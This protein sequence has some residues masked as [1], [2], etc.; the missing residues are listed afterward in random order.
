MAVAS[1][2]EGGGLS[3]VSLLIIR[4]EFNPR[5][6]N[7]FSTFGR[8]E[9]RRLRPY[10]FRNLMVARDGIEKHYRPLFSLPLQR[11]TS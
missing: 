2:I 5:V 11:Y 8:V 4:L 6:S 10:R 1:L 9:C 3:N 7:M